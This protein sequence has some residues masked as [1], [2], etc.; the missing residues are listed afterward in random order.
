MRLKPHGR[1]YKKNTPL[2]LR[3]HDDIRY[4]KR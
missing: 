3:A 1:M 2:L 4:I